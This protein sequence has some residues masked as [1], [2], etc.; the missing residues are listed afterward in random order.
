[1]ML[2]RLRSGL[3]SMAHHHQRVGAA[4]QKNLRAGGA[5]GFNRACFS[6]NEDLNPPLY[7]QDLIEM[8]AIDTGVSPRDAG[9]VLNSAFEKIMATVA[10]DSK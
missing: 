7:K 1:M 4:V 8:V 2:A 3:H 5:L 10:D 9:K 6:S